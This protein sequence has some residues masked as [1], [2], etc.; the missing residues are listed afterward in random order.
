MA[1]PMT[2]ASICVYLCSS[3]VF[4]CMVPA[5][6]GPNRLYR[7]CRTKVGP[8][9]LGDWHLLSWNISFAGGAR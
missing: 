8:R 1:S 4:Y 6:I 9:V 3:V 2:V 5:E 7:R